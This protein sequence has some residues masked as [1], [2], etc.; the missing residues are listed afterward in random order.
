MKALL[1]IVFIV[2]AAG[3]LLVAISFLWASLRALFG[4]QWACGSRRVKPS[5]GAP[6]CSTRR[7]PSCAASR[8][9]SSS[10]TRAR[11]PTRTTRRLE[12]EFRSRARRVLKQLDDDLARA[13]RQGQLLIEAELKKAGPSAADCQL[14]KRGES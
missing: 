7:K 2:L 11:S 1:P 3:T 5:D 14:A 13:P 8:I 10:R 6:S 9:S 4:G 12:A